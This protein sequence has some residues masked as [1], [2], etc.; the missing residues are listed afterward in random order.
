M[1]LTAEN[2]IDAMGGISQQLITEAMK[3]SRA[4]KE[5]LMMRM[6]TAAASLVLVVAA[7]IFAVM[8]AR[9]GAMQPGDTSPWGTETGADTCPGT[10]Y[11]HTTTATLDGTEIV[12]EWEEDGGE[13]ISATLTSDGG[14]TVKFADTQGVFYEKMLLCVDEGDD[15]YVSGGCFYVLCDLRTGEIDDFMRGE[16][17]YDFIYTD[18]PTTWEMVKGERTAVNYWRFDDSGV[19]FISVSD[20]RDLTDR[21]DTLRAMWAF[22]CNTGELLRAPLKY[23]CNIWLMPKNGP[24]THPDGDGGSYFVTAEWAAS[25]SVFKNV[26]GVSDWFPELYI[27]CSVEPDTDD[28][29]YGAKIEFDMNGRHYVHW[30]YLLTGKLTVASTGIVRGEV[31]GVEIA[32]SWKVH[33]GALVESVE[34]TLPDGAPNMDKWR[35]DGRAGDHGAVVTI[36]DGDDARIWL[37]DL[38][39]A[40]ATRLNVEP[41]LEA[42]GV[43]IGNDVLAITTSGDLSGMLVWASRAMP[44]GDTPDDVY[45]I[46]LLSPEKKCV[47]LREVPEIRELLDELADKYGYVMFDGWLGDDTSEVSVRLRMFESFEARMANDLGAEAKF[48]Y[49]PDS[50]RANLWDFTSYDTVE[51]A[52]TPQVIKETYAA[53]VLGDA[54]AVDDVII[55]HYYGNFD[56]V[57][58]ASIVVVG[59]NYPTA[60]ETETVDGVE[61][62]YHCD[63]YILA[64]DGVGVYRLAEAFERG[65]ITHDDLLRI[66]EQN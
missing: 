4:I 42:F 46:D 65:I 48:I 56:G 10:I 21:A 13:I 17:R 30:L 23:E 18:T 28:Y 7:G 58:V 44:T 53:L 22:D 47:S 52:G 35:L 8:Y 64:F 61:I 3:D 9:G 59:Q 11:T 50:G 60:F 15:D 27:K 33:T 1:R 29:N 37:F 2:V 51:S 43:N 34:V 66:A 39:T 24:Q 20:V 31:D 5:R 32:V 57:Y 38:E 36:M 12:I 62:D 49:Y 16:T 25:D 14:H 6:M 19:F 40:E 63:R 41:Q 55:Y 26:C 45:Y 54:G